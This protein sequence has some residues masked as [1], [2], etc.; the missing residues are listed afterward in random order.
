MGQTTQNGVKAP[1][2]GIWRGLVASNSITFDP[3]ALVTGLDVFSKVQLPFMAS[4]ALNR[5]IVPIKKAVQQEMLD[6]FTYVAPFT[7]KSLRQRVSDKSNLKA[8]VWI[9]YDGPKGQ[10]PSD[11]LMPQITGGQ[12]M[13][14]RF[15]NRLMRAQLMPR[16]SYMIPMLR[17]LS[18]AAKLN[19][20]GRIAPAQYTQALYGIDAMRDIQPISATGKRHPTLGSYM[21]VPYGVTKNPA[22]A[23]RLRTLGRGR[24][25]NPGIYKVQGN[26]LVQVWKQLR[27]VPTVQAKFDF[28]SVASKEAMASFPNN[29]RQV[30]R[31]TMGSRGGSVY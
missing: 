11:Y 19:A 22:Y 24:I 23:Q 10:A 28:V 21:L 14:T 18:P 15:Q 17:P 27:T 29:F 2:W 30:F 8:S 16:G 13:L 7:Y 5:T 25:P 6:R 31:E 1:S 20:Q 26:T 3:S 4:V 12:V 9:S